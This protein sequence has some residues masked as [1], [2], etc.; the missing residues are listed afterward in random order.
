M[1]KSCE[2]DIRPDLRKMAE[3]LLHTGKVEEGLPAPMDMKRLVHELHVYHAE[4]E[5]QNAELRQ[6]QLGREEVSQKY[7]DLFELSPVGYAL[8]DSDGTLIQAN[9]TCIR[10]FRLENLPLHDT[11]LSV[12]VAG[13]DRSAFSEMLSRALISRKRQ[14]AEILFR[15]SD[16]TEFYGLVSF[17]LLPGSGGQDKNLL[18]A[19]SDISNLKL[20]KQQHARQQ[21]QLRQIQKMEAIGRLAGGVAHDFNNLL[22]GILGHAELLSS[23]IDDPR[24]QGYLQNIAKTA[25]R[26]GVLTR[27]L[28]TFSR[29]T[30]V[31][32]TPVCLHQL[33]DEVLHL[34][35][36][37]VDRRITFHCDLQAKPATVK[38]DATLLQTALLNLAIN[39]RDAM[40]DGGQLSFRTALVQIDPDSWTG[41]GT[42]RD[43]GEYVEIRVQDSGVGMTPQVLEHAFEPFFTTKE[44]GQ[45]TG[46]GL[47]MV[48]GTVRGHHGLLDVT[49]TPGEG[50]EVR[51]CLPLSAEP[52]T[53]PLADY[54]PGN[55]SDNKGILLVDDE[56]IILETAREALVQ[57]GLQ[58]F[59][60][61][62]G[63]QAIEVFSRYHPDIHLVVLDATMP[64]MSGPQCL[65]YLR[66][67]APGIPAILSSG[68]IL[69][70][71]KEGL[72]KRGFTEFID[73]PYRMETLKTVVCR[74]LGQSM[75][76]ES[77]DDDPSAE[78]G[79]YRQ[80]AQ[81]PST[82]PDESQ[83]ADEGDPTSG[84]L[85]NNASVIR[86]HTTP[87]SQES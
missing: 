18:F 73:K 60:A 8:L 9:Q 28:L 50:T 82:T 72:L 36:H 22:G 37:T 55:L 81:T 75:G 84:S 65:D 23:Q 2:S 83:E 63:E 69:D 51:V 39:A 31:Q 27:N 42:P 56:E 17:T 77:S 67:I 30:S 41:Q 10:L 6:T 59:T 13:K 4:L 44:V 64:G 5:I 11:P 33:I 29:K 34:L 45:G 58:V 35:R 38:G 7:R 16:Q 46:L 79:H 54:E 52:A 85:T 43:R 66:K 80:E 49:S 32:D 20:A 40:P 14:T 86:A 24:M 62:T 68:Y 21:E 19:L 76:A 25:E 74:C 48:Y 26:A 61:G 47:S 87:D 70:D 71:E 57:A 1:A 12:F 3:Q 15:R 78:P 53:Q